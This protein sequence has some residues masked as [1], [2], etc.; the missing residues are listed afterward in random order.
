MRTDRVLTLPVIPRP[1]HG[2]VRVREIMSR[3]AATTAASALVSDARNTMEQKGTSHLVVVDSRGR[4]AGLLSEE[5]LRGA[6]PD[7]AVRIFMRSAPASFSPETTI[8]E[9]ARILGRERI[10]FLPVVRNQRPLGMVGVFEVLKMV[11]NGSLHLRRAS[12]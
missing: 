11:G 1:R 3:P 5:D 9:A 2:R 8:A 7:E 6:G 10:E 4:M 12:I